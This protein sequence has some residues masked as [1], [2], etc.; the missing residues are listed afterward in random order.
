MIYR[1]KISQVEQTCLFELSWEQGRQLTAQLPFPGR[2]TER[3]ATW[4]HLY[5][6]YY[7]FG[8]EDESGVESQSGLRGRTV[9]SGQVVTPPPDWQGQ[10]VQAEAMLLADFQDWLRQGPLFEICRELSMTTRAVAMSDQGPRDLLISCTS[11]ALERLPWETWEITQAEKKSRAGAVAVCPWRISRLPVTVPEGVARAKQIRGKASVLVVLGDATGLD[12][13]SEL[14]AIDTLKRL[15]DVHLL[16]WTPGANPQRL[17]QTICDTLQASP[18]WDMLLF[19]GHSNE[20]NTVGG[21]IAIAPNTTLSMRE[22]TPY[23]QQAKERGLQ[24]ALFNSCQGLDIAQTLI[25]LGLSQVA[26][27]REP[28]HNRVAQ[29]FLI[30]F[31]RCLAQFEDVHTALQSASW[32]LQTNNALSFPSAY[33]VPSLFRHRAGVLFRL[34]P[35]GWRAGAKAGLKSCLPHGWPA[36]RLRTSLL[37]LLT[38]LSLVVPSD[39]A[40]ARRMMARRLWSQ[41]MYR[42]LTGNLASGKA[43]TRPPVL[44]VQIDQDSIRKGIPS[45]RPNP[46][47]RAYLAS[48]VDRLSALEVRV[49]AIDY[50]LDRPQIEN[51]VRFS[52]SLQQ[53]AD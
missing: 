7:Q 27:M 39:S 9:R 31:L 10:L 21:K 36:P 46:M 37:C 8:L 28:I 12:F 43:A 25:G 1:L 40:V 24:F 3:Y 22:L 18:G 42:Q 33:L 49:I 29:S 14:K 26:I 11:M 51:D 44:L 4:Q 15:A 38:L 30:E 48:I 5:R 2:L 34:H 50:W 47:D 13:Q 23:L 52:Q 45:G 53:A 35:V 19:F 20:A 32:H 17:K 41:A 16:G 6:C